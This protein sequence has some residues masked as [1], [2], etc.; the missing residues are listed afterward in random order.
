VGGGSPDQA[1]PVVRQN[2]QFVAPVSTGPAAAA[3]APAV[4]AP[5]DA[6]RTRPPVQTRVLLGGVAAVVL[7]TAGYL[8]WVHAPTAPVTAQAAT[9]PTSI[10]VV[11]FAD[12]S[13][14]KDM[15]YFADG[16]ADELMTS[17][18]ASGRVRVAGRRSAFAFKGTNDDTRVIGERLGV[19]AV[20]E[21]SVRKD[22]QRIR[23]TA[24]LVRAQDGFSLWARTYDRAFDDVLD[25]Q[26]AIAREVTAALSPPL[27]A[28]AAT[29]TGAARDAGQTNN[30][31]AYRAF[32]RGLYFHSR[33][34]HIDMPLARDE[35]LRA[36][37]LDP[38]YARAHAWL[39]RTCAWLARRSLGD[40]EVNRGLASSAFDRALQLDPAL[41][42]IWWVR[43]QGVDGDDSAF[44]VRA[45]NF[46]QA[47]AAAP[48]DTDLMLWLGNT[49]MREGRRADALQMFARAHETDPLW[50]QAAIVLA[51]NTASWLG[52][53]PRAVSL[54]ED[55]QKFAPN[56]PRP[57]SLRAVLARADG[58]ALEWDRWITR[59]IEA[60]PRDQPLHGYLSLDYVQ[61]GLV[62]AAMYHARMCTR[63][64]PESAAG[65]Y[66]EAY[67]SLYSGNLAAA[68]PIVERARREKP[69]DYLSQ[70][71]H[72]ELLYFS[73]DC[74]GSLESLLGARPAFTR[75]ASSL[76]LIVD[77]T[78]VPIMQWCLRRLGRNTRADEV[79]RVFN[80]QYAPPYDAG[81]SSGLLARMAAA[82][83]DRD[84][85]VRH[86][87]E[88]VASNSMAFAFVRHEPMIQ[89]YLKD[90][91]V[92]A[93]LDE[94]DARRQEWVK[95][96]PKSSMRVPVR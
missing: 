65:I 6:P 5:A 29:H 54:I 28:S 25:I 13:A 64:N 82:N 53:R 59:A 46:E 86:L 7:A 15:E 34:T 90:S 12:L 16:F 10:A 2:Y 8:L 19:G 80:A 75:P 61:L 36:T 62:D 95:I 3:P 48:S 92:V 56:D 22:G 43:T 23:I 45:R 69:A 57:Y 68:R 63:L 11:P 93:L 27:G 77:Q 41:G 72:A 52:D 55:V 9:M 66:N 42:E 40:I 88:L 17:L 44:S 21:G 30:P 50:A 89:P 91:T 39:G 60:S 96:L 76:D 79:A 78:D 38:G 83:G 49:Y 31:E 20:L 67:I 51:V 35:F 73:G 70:L 94:L 58:N 81:I 26:G 37:T 32:L 71:A 1:A 74:A 4:A 24:Q 18:A 14:D 85:L 84:A 47:L 33:F 87:K